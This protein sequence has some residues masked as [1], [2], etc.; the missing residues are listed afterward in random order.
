MQLSSS[1]CLQSDIFLVR[2]SC[3]GLR[4]L[5]TV[6]SHQWL[7][8]KTEGVAIATPSVFLIADNVV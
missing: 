3:R 5:S 7:V 8:K 4:V 6:V 2:M 1:I